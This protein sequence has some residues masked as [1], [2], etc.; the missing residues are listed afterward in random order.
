MTSSK[1]DWVSYIISIAK[2]ASK[3]IEVLIL[4]WSFFLLRLL[5]IST[6]LRYVH[7]APSCYLE[8]VD[9]QATKTDMQDFWSF[10]CCF[11]WTLGSSSKCD[12]L[13]SFSIGI[14]LVDVLQNW[15]NWFY[16]LFLEGGLLVIPIDCMIFLSPFLDVTR[17]SMSTVSF[18]ALWN[19]LPIECFPLNYDLI[20]FKSRINRYLLT[21]GSF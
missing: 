10:T 5:C 3:K 13:R 14:T 15:L 19:S 18:L 16:F 6:N 7:V 4:L 8:F 11:S 9:K 2:T 17:M 12:Q 21:V 20:G 1:L